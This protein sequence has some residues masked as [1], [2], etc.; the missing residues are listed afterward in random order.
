MT[1]PRFQSATPDAVIPSSAFA[2]DDGSAPPGLVAALAGHADGLESGEQVMVALARS[3]LLVPIVA[4]LEEAGTSAAGERTDK[5]SS[6]ATVLVERADGS[7]AVLAFTST[8]TMAAWRV[9]ARPAPVTGIEAAAVAV[10]DGAT[11]LL[12]DVAGPTPFAV[13][14]GDLATLA[15]ARVVARVPAGQEGLRAA[16]VA[17][18]SPR[19]GILDAHLGVGRDV[20]LVLTVDVGLSQRD[21]RLLL[22]RVTA[23]LTG[24]REL[25]L[26][27]PGGLQL[28]VVGPSDTPTDTPSLFHPLRASLDQDGH[29]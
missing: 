6:M 10:A 27:C 5:E 12:V 3:R 15:Q 17:A 14:G 21:Y 13:T 9:D 25:T 20:E 7:R 18:L 8:A 1:K 28:R 4:V 11:A 23:D 24:S 22:E 19:P 16:V 29:P 2:D 26:A